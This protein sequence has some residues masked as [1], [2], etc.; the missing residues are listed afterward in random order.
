MSKYIGAIPVTG[1]IAPTDSNDSYP[2]AHNE[3]IKGGWKNIFDT[4]ARLA[5]PADRREIG[6]K[7][8]EISTNKLYHLIGGVE[9]TDWQEV[10]FGQSGIED[11]PNDGKMYYR[12]NNTWVEYSQ[13][14]DGADIYMNADP[15]TATIGGITAGDILNGKTANEIIDMLLHPYLVPAFT[16]FGISGVTSLEIG[17]PIPTP[18]TFAW[19]TSNSANI[20]TNTVTISENGGLV[21]AS[22]VKNDGSESV[23]IGTVVSNTVGTKTF[24]IE[25]ENSKGT[26]FT[27]TASINWVA[28]VYYG[29][30][31][32]ETLDES[33]VKSLR[34]SKLASNKSGSYVFN[35]GGY[36][37]IAWPASFGDFAA[38]KDVATNMDIVL[39]TPA[40]TTV[41]L[42]INGVVVS[43]RVYRSENILN[44]AVTA[45]IS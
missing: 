22:G 18:A 1:P 26:L 20:K 38:F 24:K 14:V 3:H 30:S 10:A 37:Y 32:Q 5:I 16:S 34:T 41:D 36:K 45:T 17:V 15:V 33:G 12:K 43:Y 28:R 4:T 7:A 21:Y 31:T 23:D 13:A 25:A 44:G 29:E 11:A 40:Y 6:M 9:D 27:R 8:Y 39:T 35:D 19:A 42:T 2:V